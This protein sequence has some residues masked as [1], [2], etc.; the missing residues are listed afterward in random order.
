MPLPA[1]G[2]LSVNWGGTKHRLWMYSMP[3]IT[4]ELFTEACQKADKLPLSF[5]GQLVNLSP[6]QWDKLKEYCRKSLN[7]LSNWE[8]QAYEQI[9][10]KA[11]KDGWMSKYGPNPVINKKKLKEDKDVQVT[12]KAEDPNQ[13]ELF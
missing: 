5:N 6:E 13:R 12:H 3:G 10:E 4:R 7:L 2:E 9:V 1:I 11:K 8:D